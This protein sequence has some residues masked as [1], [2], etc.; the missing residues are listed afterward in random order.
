MLDWSSLCASGVKFSSEILKVGIFLEDGVYKVSDSKYF[1]VD[2][3]SDDEKKDLK[4]ISVFWA[5]SESSF[6]RAYFRDVEND[7]MAKSPPPVELIPSGA[8][9]D[10]ISIRNALKAL[11]FKN[12]SEYASYRVMSDG[13]FVHKC[14]ETQ[15]FVY[16]FRSPEIVECEPPYAILL[17]QL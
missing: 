4:V 7:D 10:Y 8:D 12:F 15:K 13:A 5:C 17:K 1:L 11:D 3:F 6:R 16:Y 2:D 14:L 9:A